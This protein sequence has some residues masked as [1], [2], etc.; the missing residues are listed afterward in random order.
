MSR[1]VEERLKLF[2]KARKAVGD[3]KPGSD[4]T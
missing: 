4:N 2:A 3:G 1:A